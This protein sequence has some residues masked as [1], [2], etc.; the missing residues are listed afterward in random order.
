LRK[1]DWCLGEGNWRKITLRVGEEMEGWVIADTASKK[2]KIGRKGKSRCTI[3]CMEKSSKEAAPT[4][5]TNRREKAEGLGQKNQEG[6]EMEGKQKTG[7]ADRLVG[8]SV[9]NQTGV[10]R[11]WGEIGGGTKELSSKATR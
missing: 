10:K 3:Y 2:E 1:G 9:G 6:R 5:A 7:N 8:H 4:M 11:V